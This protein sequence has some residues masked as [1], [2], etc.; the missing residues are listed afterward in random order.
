V[1]GNK[2]GCQ[3]RRCGYERSIDGYRKEGLAKLKVKVL[4]TKDSPEIET[5]ESGRKVHER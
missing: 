5:S 4:G 1:D 2:L 3:Y